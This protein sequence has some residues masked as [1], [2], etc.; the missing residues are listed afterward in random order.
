MDYQTR[1]VHFLRSEINSLAEWPRLRSKSKT[2]ERELQKI[3]EELAS[4]SELKKENSRFTALLDLKSEI[5][6]ASAAARIIA[7]N[8]SHWSQFITINKGSADGIRLDTV[9]V[10]PHGLVGKVV[11]LA[12]HSAHAILLTDRQSRVSAINERTRDMGVV[13]GTGSA[14]L[15]MTYLD[16]NSKIQVGDIIISSGLGGVYPKGIPIGRVQ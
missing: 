14:T 7:R 5:S 11:V 2:L 13:E 10:H 16:Y 1:I 6:N 9:L 4:L 3:K 12:S 8:P 15:K